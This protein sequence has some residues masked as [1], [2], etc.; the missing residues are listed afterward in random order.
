MARRGGGGSLWRMGGLCVLSV[1]AGRA[2]FVG[3]VRV[4]VIND[5]VGKCVGLLV[6]GPFFTPSAMKLA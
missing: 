5:S 4:N 3:R 6:R 1:R 2:C